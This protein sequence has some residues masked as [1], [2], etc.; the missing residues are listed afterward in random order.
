MPLAL[1]HRE[2]D[3]DHPARDIADFL[4]ITHAVGKDRHV[5]VQQLLGTFYL[6]LRLLLISGLMLQE[7]DL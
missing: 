7:K 4:R 3:G 5:Y 6:S 2:R 1:P